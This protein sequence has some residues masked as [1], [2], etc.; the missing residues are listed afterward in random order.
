[1][2]FP[3]SIHPFLMLG[4]L[5]LPVLF[6]AAAAQDQPPVATNNQD[7]VLTIPFEAGQSVDEAL[8][9]L[10]SSDKFETNDY[11]THVFE[12]FNTRAYEMRQHIRQAVEQEKGNVRTASTKPTDGSRSRQFLVVTTTPEQMPT[13]ADAIRTLDVHGFVNSQG[14]SRRAFRVKYRRASDLAVVLES[15]R[16]SGIGDIFADDLTNTLYYDDTPYVA[17]AVEEYV[18]FF[19]VPVPQ[20]EFDVQIIEVREDNAEKLG[21]DWDAWKRSVGGQLTATGNLFEGGEAFGRLDGLLTLEASVLAN[22]L[23]YTVQ[24]GNARLVQRSRLNASNLQPAVI[25]DLKRVPVYGYE[26]EKG[27]G[28]VL[29]ESN[30]VA[31]AGREVSPRD[32]ET[33]GGPRTV[34]IVPPVTN[35]RVRLA[36]DQEGIFLS[37]DPVIAA[38]SVT[39]DIDIAINTV[40]GFDKLD[41]PIVTEQVLDN[42]FT[43]RDGEKLLLGSLE[44]E[45]AVDSRRGIP[46]LKDLP[47]LKHL[48]SVE[49]S[50]TESSRLF[51]LATPRFSH[52]GYAA[53]TLAEMDDE[54]VLLIRESSP[55]L[56]DG[57]MRDLMTP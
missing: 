46:G 55:V 32:G 37:I 11:V 7:E 24:Q 17:E 41:R 29:T 28:N 40:V 23:N 26:P 16:L 57:V 44:R 19:D 47:V 31:D 38:H 39:A 1:M 22:F 12:V 45:V 27:G 4:A 3:F 53:E 6:S 8:A 14:S 43:L 56:D 30:P 25:S 54:G 5:T 51:I 36:S 9:I 18:A 48:F 10:R 52:I 20:I 21:L 50:R 33:P 15:T 49:V 34:A 35:R 13:I 42:Q 2:R